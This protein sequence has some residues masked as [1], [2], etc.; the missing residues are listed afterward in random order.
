[1][2]HSSGS[3]RAGILA[4]P[5]HYNIEDT[6]EK[7]PLYPE[8]PEI[9]DANRA[10]VFPTIGAYYQPDIFPAFYKYINTELPLHQSLADWY[11]RLMPFLAPYKSQLMP[12]ILEYCQ[13]HFGIEGT[14]DELYAYNLDA[15]VKASLAIFASIINDIEESVV[16]EWARKL[17]K[18]IGLVNEFS[19]YHES[20]HLLSLQLHREVT[21]EFKEIA[22][23]L[24]TLLWQQTVPETQ[25]D[26]WI[27]FHELNDKLVD[28]LDMS[29]AL[30][31]PRATIFALEDLPPESRLLIINE[32]YPEERDDEEAHIFHSLHAL[33]GG[34]GMVAWPLTFLAE[35]L[36]PSDPLEELKDLLFVL[37]AKKAFTW[38]EEQWINWI[39]QWN[40]LQEVLDSFDKLN[41][42]PI[43]GY[44][45]PRATIQALP[46]NKII[47]SCPD[48]ERVKLF[49]E[50]MRQ[51]LAVL[52]LRPEHIRSLICPFKRRRTTCCRLGHHL[53]GI[54]A[55]IPSVYRRRL[56]PPAMDCMK[57]DMV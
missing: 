24:F 2:R 54:W 9:E 29:F 57:M 19:I 40:E 16:V 34:R 52:I 49:L 22:S 51:Q 27:R 38:T 13:S 47:I 36:N 23:T 8:W 53:R 14:I 46:E 25:G 20:Q 4:C 12:M 37:T 55:G 26:F 15:V 41:L 30:E 10:H 45:N 50:S 28:C 17:L 11:V 35:I 18:E 48:N 43:C 1:M 42:D 21:N 44:F 7:F 3:R 32:V 56:I 6:V 39:E 31:E 33:T 5:S